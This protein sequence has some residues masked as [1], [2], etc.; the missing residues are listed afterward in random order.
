MFKDIGQNAFWI[1]MIQ[2]VNFL[3]P[4]VALPHISRVLGPSNFGIYSI[5]LVYGNYVLLFSDFSF[6]VNG[7]LRV[8]DAV[9]EQ[10]LR[11]LVVNA[12]FL[13][14]ILLIPASIVYIAAI[15][16]FT[17]GSV[18]YIVA[19]L[20]NAMMLAL[21]PRWI[22][23]GLG[24]LRVFALHS[25]ISKGIWLSL[26][27]LIINRSDDSVILLWLTAGSQAI[28]SFLGF[29]EVLH[30]AKGQLR[31]SL[32]EVFKIFER[33]FRQFVAILATS[34]LRDMAILLLSIFVLPSAL[35]LYSIADRVRFA[36]MSVV[37]PVSQ[38]LFLLTARSRAG[39]GD[40][41][42]QRTRGFANIAILFA[43]FAN[44]LVVCVFARQI[45][46]LI[47]GMKYIGAVNILRVISFV[48]TLTAI[49]SIMG[50]NTL[51]SMGRQNEYA[52]AQMQSV[53]LS[54]PIL[55]FF[56]LKF[57]IYGAA[58]GALFCESVMV[59][60]LTLACARCNLLK[61]TFWIMN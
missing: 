44:G 46:L 40:D 34:S 15:I 6:N 27:Y 37:A 56:T 39:V 42:D 45:I 32:S 12:T 23:Y 3:M 53:F 29:R 49:N 19:G 31:I 38:S 20:V 13:K 41:L 5:A 48:P 22:M 51:L 36:I 21:T 30:G 25:V 33:D 24:R 9:R 14:A 17:D 50:V 59:V 35:S 7:A 55:I 2:G 43:A 60:M 16:K 8:A 61:K 10:N 58:W 18:W 11:E 47:G 26:I 54:F 57:G 28:L 4:L 1:V 52:K